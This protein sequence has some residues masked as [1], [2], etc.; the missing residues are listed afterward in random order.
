MSR[1]GENRDSDDDA[2]ESE[3]APEAHTDGPQVG[4]SGRR[5]VVVPLRL[6][7]TI[8]V[9]ST[10]FAVVGILAGFILLDVATDRAQADLAEVNIVVSL[11]GIGLIV[12]G[13]A[14]YAFSTRFRTEGMGNAKDDTDEGSDN[15]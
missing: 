11:L 9:F 4:A 5:E 15:G 7:K 14:T 3:H 10:L 1:A 13:S 2:P 6:Y 8:T 12:L